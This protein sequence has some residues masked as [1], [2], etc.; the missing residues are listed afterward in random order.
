MDY[1]TEVFENNFIRL[2]NYRLRGRSIDADRR[3]IVFY[4][5]NVKKIRSNRSYKTRSGAKL[6]KLS[7]VKNQ[8]KI[9]LSYGKLNLFDK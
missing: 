9:V 6:F 4:L 8:K 3:T 1:V 2:S 5:P 7:V